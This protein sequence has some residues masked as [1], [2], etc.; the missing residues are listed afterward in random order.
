MSVQKALI[1][2]DEQSIAESFAKLSVNDTAK[3]HAE[4]FG[5]R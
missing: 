2:E 3:T 1:D 4:G 5:R